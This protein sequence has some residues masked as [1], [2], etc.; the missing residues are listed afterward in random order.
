MN[1]LSEPEIEDFKMTAPLDAEDTNVL[2]RDVE[3]VERLQRNLGHY[4]AGTLVA[5]E[6]MIHLLRTYNEMHDLLSDLLAPFALTLGKYNLLIVLYSTPEHHLPMSEIGDRMSV[7]RTNI[8]KLVDM[9]E[10]EGLVQRVSVPADRRVTLAQLT[11]K[12][13]ELLQRIMPLHYANIRRLWSGMD[14]DDCLQLT[15]L[16]LKLRRSSEAAVSAG[17]LTD[18]C[19]AE[20]KFR[21]GQH[22]GY[23]EVEKQEVEK[24]EVEK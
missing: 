13:A 24:Q 14:A 17:L 3:I 22:A 11:G 18:V 15:H 23:Q 20:Q 9:L 4:D 12:G 1:K 19:L 2:L 5:V 8:T 10:Q 6:S 16:L 21:A 7:T